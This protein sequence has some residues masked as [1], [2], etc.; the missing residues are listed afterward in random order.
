MDVV[1]VFENYGPALLRGGLLTLQLTAVS[2]VF[3]TLLGVPLGVLGSSFG[4]GGRITSVAISV[5]NEVVKA[6]PVLI[7]LIWFQYLL[8][9]TFG[10]KLS[11]IVVAYIALSLNL[12]V[13]LGESIRGSLDGVP[14]LDIEAGLALGMSKKLVIRRILV[15][16]AWRV[17]LPGVFVLYLNTLKLSTLASVIAVPEILHT[18]DTVILN[19][20]R[21]L[22]VYTTVALLFLVVVVPVSLIT[23]RLEQRLSPQR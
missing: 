18:A 1:W 13:Y 10:I 16:Q 8:P 15:P 9:V 4:A 20:F 17:S 5:L 19:S 22:D 21:A 23:R 14:K 12:A 7:L 2:I 6:L 3:G 11:A